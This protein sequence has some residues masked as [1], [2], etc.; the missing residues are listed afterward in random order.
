MGNTLSDDLIID[1]FPEAK[2]IIPVKLNEYWKEAGE[3]YATLRGVR[4]IV[5][6]TQTDDFSKWFFTQ[7]H[8]YKEGLR[9]KW[10]YQ[11]IKR[12][13][14]LKVLQE[15]KEVSKHLSQ[16]R[17]ETKKERDRFDIDKMFATENLLV[18]IASFHGLTLKQTGTIYMGKCPFHEDSSPSFA[19]YR[20]NWYHCFGCGAHGNFLNFLM[21]KSNLTFREALEEANGYL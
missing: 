12:L 17:F 9:L 19:I 15:K 1:A 21:I 14:R 20:D 8:K 7:A 4:D 13:E 5:D 10:L 16:E 2:E 18:D 6:H 11:Q 3:L